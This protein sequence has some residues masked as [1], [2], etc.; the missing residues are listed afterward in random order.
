MSNPFYNSPDL[1]KDGRMNIY[2]TQKKRLCGNFIGYVEINGE[3]Y[4]AHPINEKQRN[5]NSLY[6]AIAYI[7]GK[8]AI[9]EPVIIDEVVIKSMQNQLTLF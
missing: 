4:I 1:F 7:F 9:Y 3:S 8:I 6:T 5:F 2:D